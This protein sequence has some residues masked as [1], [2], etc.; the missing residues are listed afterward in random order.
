MTFVQGFVIPSHDKAGYISMAAE[1]APVFLDHGARR[2][3]ETWAVD[4][5]DGK[6]TDMKKAVALEDGE[7]VVF[8]WIFYDDRESFDAAHDKI[9]NDPRMKMP[10]TMPF[11]TKRMIFAGFDVVYDSGDS[12]APIG[13]VDGMVAAVPSDKRDAFAA[14]AQ[15]HGALF[16]EKGALRVV[17]GWGV[18][19]PEGKLTDFRRSVDLAEGETV[20]FGWIEW[21]DKAT[22]DAAWGALMSDPRMAEAKPVWNGPTAIFGGFAP[23]F[24][25][26]HQ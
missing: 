26:A 24:D 25:T 17:D 3:V 5:P 7:D 2:I 14:F 23:V 21:P 12:G 8:S 20:V 10:E 11:D 16:K 9:F 6:R 13:F 15:G 19:V 4:V 22:R 18:D 1:G